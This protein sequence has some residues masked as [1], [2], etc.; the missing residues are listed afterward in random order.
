M[1]R[2]T[3]YSLRDMGTLLQVPKWRIAYLFESNQLAEP[4]R[5]GGHRIFTE[6]DVRRIAAKLSIELDEDLKVL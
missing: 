5:V 2:T 4:M 3:L 6:D 1:N